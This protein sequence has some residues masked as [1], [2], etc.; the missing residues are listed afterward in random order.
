[1]RKLFMKIFRK[2]L[3]SGDTT[4]SLD[5]INFRPIPPDAFR[6]L[7]IGNS[8]TVHGTLQGVWDVACGMAASSPEKDFV[9][10]VTAELQGQNVRPVE[11]LYNNGGNGKIQEMLEYLQLRDLKPDLVILQGGENDQLNDDFRRHYPALLDYFSVPRIVLGDWYSKDK[12]DYVEGLCEKRDVPFVRLLDISADKGMSG[13]GGPFGNKDV[14]S[15]PNDA[16]MASI[17]DAVVAIWTPS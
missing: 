2:R 11:A 10:M 5:F 3:N 1:M 14:S 6:V 8:L 7:F 16:G 9:H 15:H 17:A 4:S 13:Y 12:S